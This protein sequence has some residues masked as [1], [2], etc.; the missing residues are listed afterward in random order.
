MIKKEAGCAQHKSW[1]ETKTIL[2]NRPFWHIDAVH[3]FV[4]MNWIWFKCCKSCAFFQIHIITLTPSIRIFH[5]K[6][7][8]LVTI[9]KYLGLIIDGD[10]SFRVHVQNVYSNLRVKIGFYYRN[11]SCFS[12]RAQKLMISSIFLPTLDYGDVWI[13][14]LHL[15]LCS[16][17]LQSTTDLIIGCNGLT[18]HCELYDKADIGFWI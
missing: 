7:L 1:K 11:K 17:W 8:E 9:D 13:C 4:Y 15:A 5:C 16:P 12:L 6:T 18:H 2:T 3:I 10:F 14:G